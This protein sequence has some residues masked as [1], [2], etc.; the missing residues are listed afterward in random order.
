MTLTPMVAEAIAT[1]T[2]L[3]FFVALLEGPLSV[4]II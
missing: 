2:A 3:T 1:K 4:G